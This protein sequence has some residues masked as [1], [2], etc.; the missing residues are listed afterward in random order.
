MKIKVCGLKYTDNIKAVEDLKPDYMGFIFYE[1]SPR[2]VSGLNENFLDDI[3]TDIIKTGVFVNEHADAISKL[4]YKYKLDAIQLHGAED[5]EFCDLFK[6]EVQVIKAFGVDE[7]FDFSQLKAYQNN[8]NFFLFDTKTIAHGG[9]GKTFDWNVLK[10]YELNVPFLLSGGLSLENI[11]EIKKIDHPM[12]Y[13]VDL[14]SRFEISP[15]MKD[16]NKLTQAFNTI[17]NI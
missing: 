15:G 9:S 3:P 11:E 2:F 1:K 5:P 12:L 10:K 14:N 8:V 17:K 4:I 7:D 16:I 13:G 6:H